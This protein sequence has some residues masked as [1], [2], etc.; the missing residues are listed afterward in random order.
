[1]AWHIPI[2]R[3]LPD[4]A[5]HVVEPV[6]IWWEAADGCY[7]CI[8]VLFGVEDRKDALPTIGNGL[9]I[10][11]EGLAPILSL[12]AAAS[13]GIFP[14]CLRRKLAPQPM[15]IGER[16]LIGDMNNGMVLLTL[17]R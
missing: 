12:I 5:D 2:A 10:L 6:S 4:I 13:R 17:D 9:A 3:P 8:A 15:R 14:L 7:A 11:V 16:I 1:M